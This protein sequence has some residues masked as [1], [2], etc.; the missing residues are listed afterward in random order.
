MGNASYETEKNSFLGERT[1]RYIERSYSE[2]TAEAMDTA[3]R[4]ILDEVFARA[5]NILTRNRDV[6]DRAAERLLEV[7]TLDEAELL[8][9]ARSLQTDVIGGPDA[10]TKFPV[11]D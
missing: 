4:D 2:A 3:V 6:L 10:V 8:D 1:P 9:V 7:E 5:L 11:P